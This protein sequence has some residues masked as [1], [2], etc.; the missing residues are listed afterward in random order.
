MT[1]GPIL[2]SSYIPLSFLVLPSRDRSRRM[3]NKLY[4]NSFC[5]SVCMWCPLRKNSQVWNQ[6][7]DLYSEKQLRIVKSM[8]G[9]D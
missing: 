4:E 6:D 7:K 1:P 3:V 2:D 5:P 8:N 9:G